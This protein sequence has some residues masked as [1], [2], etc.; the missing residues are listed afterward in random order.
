M[1]DLIVSAEAVGEV[2]EF[3]SACS[4]AVYV[5]DEVEVRRSAK[6]TRKTHALGIARRV[7]ALGI[8]RRVGMSDCVSY[9]FV[10]EVLVL[11][12]VIVVGIVVR[13]VR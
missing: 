5:Y 11:V 6:A 12:L 13:G 8:A 3:S 10:L 1:F 7:G 4:G 2:R 9:L